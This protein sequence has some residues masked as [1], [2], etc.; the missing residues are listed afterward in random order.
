MNPARGGSSVPEL[1]DPQPSRRQ[2]R[3]PHKSDSCA[4]LA[5]NFGLND[6]SV[7]GVGSAEFVRKGI[8]FSIDSVQTA[9]EAVSL[10]DGL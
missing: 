5:A 10:R 6:A 8:R 4:T 9:G 1:A 7:S 2:A 3:F